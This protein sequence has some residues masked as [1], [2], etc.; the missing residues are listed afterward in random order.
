VSE[1][2]VERAMSKHSVPRS[3]WLAPTGGN[4]GK[5]PESGR[6]S[7]DCSLGAFNNLSDAQAVHRPE[8][9]A[10][11][12]PLF[13]WRERPCQWGCSTTEQLVCLRLYEERK[14]SP[15]FFSKDCNRLR[16]GASV[17]SGTKRSKHR[18]MT[19]ACPARVF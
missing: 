6:Q 11:D 19:K 5:P 18:M 12:C 8:S 17:S 2:W 15:T 16:A 14:C 13:Q 3:L 10:S 1:D 4:A 7:H 9:C